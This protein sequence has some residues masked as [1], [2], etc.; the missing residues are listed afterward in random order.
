[1]ILATIT[2]LPPTWNTRPVTSTLAPAGSRASRQDWAAAFSEVFAQPA[3]AVEARTWATALGDEYPAEHAQ[4]V[5]QVRR[6]L[7]EMA[8]TVD[9]MIRRVL[10]V[11]ERR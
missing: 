2:G 6:D 7:A 1:M 5:D 9:T 4:P 3:G 8:A 10:I 11:A